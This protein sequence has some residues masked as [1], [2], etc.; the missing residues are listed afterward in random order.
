MCIFKYRPTSLFINSIYNHRSCH[1]DIL[2]ESEISAIFL[3]VIY[4]L[5]T[6]SVLFR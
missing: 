5:F 1:V 6:K 2:W 4:D 3:V